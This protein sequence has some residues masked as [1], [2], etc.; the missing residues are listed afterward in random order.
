[1]EYGSDSLEIHQ[2]ALP[3]GAGVVLIDDLL[4]TGGTALAATKLLQQCGAK[5]ELIQFLI[6]L[7][8]LNGISK[9]GTYNCS[10]L[11]K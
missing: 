6:E 3:R 9:L 2:D 7:T 1:L 10:T 8:F 4:A 11:I 5:I